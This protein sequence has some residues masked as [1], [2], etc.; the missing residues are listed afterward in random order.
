MGIEF[1]A[2]Q[3]SVVVAAYEFQVAR[4]IPVGNQVISD[5]IPLP[6]S[7]HRFYGCPIKKC[8]VRGLEK[9]IT[10][11]CV[12]DCR[13]A[14]FRPASQSRRCRRESGTPFGR[15]V[16]AR[17][18]RSAGNRKVPS[19]PE[20]GWAPFTNSKIRGLFAGCRAASYRVAPM[21]PV[22]G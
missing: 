18:R 8:I 17:S 11:L 14:P 20:K 22:T 2:R 1:W 9:N 6:C 5:Q 13:S 15:G 16:P 21:L 19:G 12:L 7:W 3:P 10:H 4:N